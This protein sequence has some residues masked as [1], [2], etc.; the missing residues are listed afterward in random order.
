MCCI[1]ASFKLKHFLSG[2]VVRFMGFRELICTKFRK[3]LKFTGFTRPDP[4]II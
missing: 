4:K 1:A 2:K 3:H